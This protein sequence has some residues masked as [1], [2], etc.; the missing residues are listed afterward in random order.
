MQQPVDKLGPSETDWFFLIA[1]CCTLVFIQFTVGPLYW[2]G[3]EPKYTFQG[4]GLFTNHQFY[5]SRSTWDTFLHA[6]GLKSEYI[7]DLMRPPYQTLSPSVAY[8]AVLSRFGLEAAR[9]SNFAIGCSGTLLLLL[10]L[11]AGFAKDVR[12]PRYALYL[13]LATVSLSLPFVEYLKLLYPEVLLFVVIAGALYS[14]F[15]GY[16]Y[17]TLA[18]VVLL[19]FVHLRALP[20]A[21]AFGALLLW[22]RRKTAQPKSIVSI[23]L[24]LLL[25]FLGLAAYQ[26]ALNGSFT[27]VASYMFV[28]SLAMLPERVGMELFGVRHGVAAYS[29]IFLVG[30][31][32]LIAGAI[33]RNVACTYA[34]ILLSS[35][36]TTFIWSEASESWSARFWVAAL[37]FIAV[38][39]CYWVSTSRSWFSYL[40]VVPLAIISAASVA[41]F[42][43]QPNAFLSNR[44]TSIPYALIANAVPLDFGLVLPVDADPFSLIPPYTRPIA[45]VLAF[46]VLLVGLLVLCNLLSSARAQRLTSAA[47][48]VTLLVVAGFC[49]VRPMSRSAFVITVEPRTNKIVIKMMEPDVSVSAIQFDDKLAQ[50]WSPDGGFPAE[51]IIRCLDGARIVSED[52]QPSRP[53]LT[54]FN[55]SHSDEIELRGVPLGK[56]NLFFKHPGK[57]TL[58][59]RV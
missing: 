20:L 26:Y 46:A 15:A 29:P 59:Q 47:A 28:P 12:P 30:F 4:L 42:I 9:W 48:L 56:G 18:L 45:Y 27:G 2:T 3:D 41:I 55:C 7:S 40:P 44:Q 32:G 21:V 13:A 54:L 11:K 16:R 24:L 39:L 57:I 58:M 35:Y 23:A 33:R 8:G 1:I 31:A 36:V 52:L 38:G 10:L 49:F 53:L 22:D 50:Y 19:P 25:G 5:P 37:P 17:I 6:N 14:L 51:F 34:L 43:T